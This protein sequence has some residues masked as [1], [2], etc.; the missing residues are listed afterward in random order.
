VAMA[1][2]LLD[3]RAPGPAG[4]CDNEG[5]GLERC[6][7]CS[8]LIDT[9]LL[10]GGESIGVLTGFEVAGVNGFT[11]IFDSLSSSFFKNE[12]EIVNGADIE[13]GIC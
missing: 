1:G 4:D 11:A 13:K 6:F 9:G 12:G 3:T 5:R 10:F 2:D 8:D 7:G